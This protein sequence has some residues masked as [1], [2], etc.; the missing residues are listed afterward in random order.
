MNYKWKVEDIS[1]TRG[2][3]DFKVPSEDKEIEVLE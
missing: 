2:E 3:C 1:K